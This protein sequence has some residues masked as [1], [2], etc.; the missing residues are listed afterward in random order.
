M[1][2][3]EFVWFITRRWDHRTPSW[4]PVSDS[5]YAGCLEFRATLPTRTARHLQAAVHTVWMPGPPAN[6]R[7]RLLQF[8]GFRKTDERWVCTA[9]QGNDRVYE[10]AVERST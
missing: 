5:P 4:E 2:L 9:Y 7:Q 1:G 3:P 8:Y 6:P 10:L